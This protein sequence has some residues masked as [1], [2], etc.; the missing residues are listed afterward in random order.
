MLQAKSIF[1][2]EISNNPYLFVNLVFAFFP[3]SFIF[4]TFIFQ[5]FIFTIIQF[6]E[7][8]SINQNFRKKNI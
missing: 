2:K 8:N 1:Q 3:F 4:G 7:V 5:F 6:F